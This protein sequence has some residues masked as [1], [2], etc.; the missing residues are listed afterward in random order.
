MK[1]LMNYVKEVYPECSDS[2]DY[3]TIILMFFFF[4]LG[5]LVFYRSKVTDMNQIHSIAKL[6]NSEQNE[7]KLSNEL[8][9]TNMK[10]LMREQ[11]F[12]MMEN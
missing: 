8:R 11:L 7:V 3:L 6:Q 9:M 12:F 10:D 4:I 5:Y 1:A 2:F